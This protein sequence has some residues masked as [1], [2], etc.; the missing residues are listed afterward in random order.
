[1]G[2]SGEKEDFSS[3]RESLLKFSKGDGR[4]G[5]GVERGGVSSFPRLSIRPAPKGKNRTLGEQFEKKQ[6]A[7][8][9]QVRIGEKVSE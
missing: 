3:A 1:V 9:S 8:T 7:E 6:P 4:T 2:G 5:I